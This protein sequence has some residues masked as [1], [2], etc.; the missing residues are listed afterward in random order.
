MELYN[1]AEDPWEESPTIPDTLP[2]L[3]PQWVFTYEP[4]PEPFLFVRL[5]RFLEELEPGVV[6]FSLKSGGSIFRF[7]VPSA[8]ALELEVT[9]VQL[10]TSIHPA[11]FG[12]GASH[13]LAGLSSGSQKM[14]LTI[15]WDS[16]GPWRLG[17][18]AGVTN[19]NGSE[20]NS[21][22]LE[23]ALKLPSARYAGYCEVDEVSGRV[24]WCIEMRERRS[25]FAVLH[26]V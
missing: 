9:E 24:L 8:N 11:S 4:P 19:V 17:T 20:N 14:I 7:R 21:E 12:V 22:A 1:S 3:A 25:Q 2:R 16:L 10:S 6:V 18:F 23:G 26:F 13:V 5:S 15:L